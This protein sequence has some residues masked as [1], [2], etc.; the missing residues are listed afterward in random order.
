MTLTKPIV[1]VDI[2]RPLAM[3]EEGLVKRTRLEYPEIFTGD[4][5]TRHDWD[6]T[7]GLDANQKDAV[8]TV[9][10]LEG[11][12]LDLEPV[13]GAREALYEMLEE[14]IEVFLCS[15]P[16]LNNPTCAS[17][18]LA[19]VDAHYG[20][21]ITQRTILTQD[22]TLVYGQ[23]LVDDKPV[24]KGVMIPSWTQVIFDSA[25]NQHVAGH[26]LIDWADWRDAILPV[27]HLDRIA[28]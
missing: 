19:W 11:F 5:G 26:R 25:Y 10:Q 9:M 27:L 17:D 14:D 16:S 8:L 22:K 20:R 3:W 2:D 21:E 18:K 28:A 1:L 7:L 15:T 6:L 13:A 12:Y 24:L 23:A 4:A